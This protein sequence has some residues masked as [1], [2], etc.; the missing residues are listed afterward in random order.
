M[1]YTFPPYVLGSAVIAPV[2]AAAAG[3][4]LVRTSRRRA[5]GVALLALALVFGALIAPML[6][7]DRIVVDEDRIEQTTGLWFAPTRHHIALA[8]VR[9]VAIRTHRD[10]RLNERES[11]VFTMTDGRSVEFMAGTLWKMHREAII[12]NLEASGI[13]FR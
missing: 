3:I 5:L 12:A 10:T 6:A 1:V 11:W 8:E 7:R 2:L 4:V 9:S 13:A